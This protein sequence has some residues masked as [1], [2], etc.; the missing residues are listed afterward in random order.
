MTMCV[1]SK[2]TSYSNFCRIRREIVDLQKEK[3]DEYKEVR[4]NEQKFL[5]LEL[6]ARHNEGKRVIV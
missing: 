1:F 6:P 2:S 4:N 5:A 3:K